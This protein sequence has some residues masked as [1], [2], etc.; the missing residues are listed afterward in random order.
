MA[1]R[2]AVSTEATEMV[3]GALNR[4][5]FSS[6]SALA[7]TLSM[8]QADVLG[9]LVA[10][11]QAGLAV[12]DPDGDL[13]RARALSREP[14]PLDRL[15]FSNERE[16]KARELFQRGSVKVEVEER[17]GERR[18]AGIVDDGKTRFPVEALIDGDERLIK[19]KCS[20]NFFQQNRLRLGPCEHILA[21]RMAK[22]RYH[23]SA[24]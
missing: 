13:W 1:P 19:A 24:K 11:T 22:A 2:A 18:I 20:C 16:A 9:A 15:R 14:L 21:A 3:L 17:I 8:P 6:A 10:G 7:A 23:F 4:S 12:K 5:W